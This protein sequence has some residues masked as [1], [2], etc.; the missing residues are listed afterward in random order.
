MA[1]GRVWMCIVIS[2]CSV[3]SEREGGRE[4]AIDQEGFVAFV[5]KSWEDQL[6]CEDEGRKGRKGEHT[7]KPVTRMCTS[8]FLC[9]AVVS[10]AWAGGFAVVGAIVLVICG[11]HRGHD[12][13]HAPTGAR[14]LSRE[15]QYSRYGS[16]RGRHLDD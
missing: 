12:L 13:A 16:I 6:G 11:L 14:T 2:S 5:W 9:A 10:S 8:F 15:S 1:P 7:P 4:D 3:I